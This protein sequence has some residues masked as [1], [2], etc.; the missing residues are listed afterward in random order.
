MSDVA[1]ATPGPQFMRLSPAVLRTDGGTQQRVRINPRVIAEF[2]EDMAEGRWVWDEQLPAKDQMKAAFDGTSYWLWDGLTR[3]SAAEVAHLET[4]LVLV[5]HSTLQD[6]V[7]F[8]SSANAQHGQRRTNKD[9]QQAVRAALLHPRATAMSDRD[10]AAHVGVSNT[11]VSAIVAELKGEGL[12][13]DRAHANN[14]RK[15]IGRVRNGTP[16]QQIKKWWPNA[17]A[18]ER[19]AVKAWVLAQ[20]GE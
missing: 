5:E 3:H 17:P 11:M 15:Q 12:L 10:I 8:S 6:A 1:T 18:A 13:D 2:A 14:A 19:H 9:K 4:V 7:W 20:G 16:L